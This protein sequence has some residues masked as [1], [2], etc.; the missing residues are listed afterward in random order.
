MW[1]RVGEQDG[2]RG[3]EAAE[4]RHGTRDLLEHEGGRAESVALGRAVEL[5]LVDDGGGVRPPQSSTGPLPPPPW[6][7]LLL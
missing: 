3:G 6:R 2:E 7:P 4:E 5:D 1:T